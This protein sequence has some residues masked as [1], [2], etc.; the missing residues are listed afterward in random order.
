MDLKNRIVDGRAAAG[1]GRQSVGRRRCGR[2]A[3]GPRSVAFR[4]AGSPSL[5]DR[6]FPRQAEVVD[7]EAFAH[8]FS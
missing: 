8:A 1:A 3:A 5:M 6:V 7:V 4:P 2:F